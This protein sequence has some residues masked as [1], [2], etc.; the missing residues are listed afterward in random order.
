MNNILSK[1]IKHASE[2][3]PFYRELYSK[4]KV[5]ISV[6]DNQ[7]E[8][9]KKIPIVK[10][11]SF[12]ESDYSTISKESISKY[13]NNE[14][15][16]IP[17]S[18]STGKCLNVFWDEVDYKKSLLPLWMLRKTRYGITPKDNPCFF[19]TNQYFENRIIHCEDIIL[20]GNQML[21]N[22]SNWDKY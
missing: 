10:K 5:D 18:G 20:N 6:S 11:Q 17:T 7:I 1:I 8:D 3:V 15:I 14:L 13:Y 9:I 12:L 2:N 22:K 21:I 4:N 19:F 16:S